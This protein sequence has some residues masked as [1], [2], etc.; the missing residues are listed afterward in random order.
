MTEGTDH[1]ETTPL[2]CYVNQWTC[3]YMIGTSAMK[4]LM[5][6]LSFKPR[7]QCRQVALQVRLHYRP[8]ACN[9]IKKRV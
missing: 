7:L 6:Q 8:E 5:T 9:F 2:I 1:I 4:E 3:F